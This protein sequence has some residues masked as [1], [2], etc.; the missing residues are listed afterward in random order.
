M[1][2]ERLAR[3]RVPIA[4]L[5]GIATFVLAFYLTIDDGRIQAVCVE[6]P[7]SR[8]SPPLLGR[9][10]WISGAAGAIAIGLILLAIQVY[11]SIRARRRQW[12]SASGIRST[13]L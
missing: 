12:R 5:G 3:T 4:L 11:L 10:L 9:A 8:M 2:G 6:G 1:V 13:S 7:C